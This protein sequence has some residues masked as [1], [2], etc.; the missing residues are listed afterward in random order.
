[1]DDGFIHKIEGGVWSPVFTLPRN[2]KKVFSRLTQQGIPAYLPLKRHVNVQSVAGNGKSY[3]YKRVLHVPMFTNYLFV[4]VTPEV[5]SELNWDRS[6]VRVLKTDERQEST[7]IEELKVIRELENF[8]EDEEIDVTFGLKKG[9]RVV[10]TEGL[11]RGW[12][13]VILSV[14]PTGMVYINITSVAASVEVKYPAAWCLVSD[15]P[16]SAGRVETVR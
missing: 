11:F 5:L 3:S 4:N 15:G 7:L 6:V 12:S 2:E 1:M 9:K 8:S 16:A 13:G 14:E 10:F